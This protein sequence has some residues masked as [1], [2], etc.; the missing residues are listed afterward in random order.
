MHFAQ[1][2]TPELAHCSY[3]IG[4][5]QK[6]VVVDPSRDVEKYFKQADAF[7]MEI[8]GV[9]ITHLHADFVSG[10]LELANKANA[11]I[12]APAAANCEFSYHPLKD[13]EEFT[14]ENLCFKLTE[15]P[16]HTPDSSFVTVFDLERGK[17]PILA[18]TGDTLLVGDV[19]RP[20]L[21]PDK[22]EELAEEL[23]ESL[24][25]FD[26]L[27]DS[28]EIYPAHG[29]GSLCGRSLS[30]KLSSTMGTERKYNYALQYDELENFK[31]DLLAEMP[32]APD[33]FSRCS[34]IN[35]KGPVLMDDLDQPKPMDPNEVNNAIQEGKIVLDT[36][37]FVSFAAAHIPKS[38]SIT[39]S[40][41]LSKFAGWIIP[42]D[43]EIIL[44]MDHEKDLED[45]KNSLYHV[46]LDNI[47]GY[48][49]GGIEGWINSG[50][51]IDYIESMS[52]KRLYEWLEEDHP[53]V[54]DN[55][56]SDEWETGYVPGSKLAPAP[57][58]RFLYEEWSSEKPVVTICNTSKRSMLAASILKQKGFKRV[59]NV[60]GGM[61]A[62]KNAGYPL[63]FRAEE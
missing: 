4:K 52:V 25:K 41:N 62:W 60:M 27:P 35:R 58:V 48:L 53:L 43:D 2:Y 13:S 56:S 31:E 40:G 12:Y 11:T 45:V 51:L 7:G 22:E 49:K 39:K 26:E 16:G 20:D 47:V 18:F 19:G 42:P 9:L 55:R 24:K 14:V 32:P 10:H 54:I 57:D 5:N 59:I 21:F 30:A 23:F 6:C 44:V 46:G 1:I 36:R 37:S 61:T 50:F 38:Y 28:C 33:H 3:V 17:D 63:Q 34:E 8:V 15:T 29:M